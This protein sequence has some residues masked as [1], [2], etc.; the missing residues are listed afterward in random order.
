MQEQVKDWP[1]RKASE[2]GIW[3]YQGVLQTRLELRFSTVHEDGPFLS[4][5][6]NSGHWAFL[7]C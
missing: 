1:I 2:P 5:D 4:W 6:L 7:V 3:S